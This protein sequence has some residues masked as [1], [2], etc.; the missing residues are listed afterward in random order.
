MFG[1]PKGFLPGT[2]IKYKCNP[3]YSIKK[4]NTE[5]EC[6]ESYNDIDWYPSEVPLCSGELLALQGAQWTTSGKGV[7]FMGAWG[8]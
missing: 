5:A 7:N 2:K 4:G 6:Q 1:S 8:D 3:G